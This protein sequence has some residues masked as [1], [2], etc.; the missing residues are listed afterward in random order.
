LRIQE[1]F[2][3][4]IGLL[5]LGLIAAFSGAAAAESS[6]N[7]DEAQRWTYAAGGQDLDALKDFLGRFTEST[8]APEARALLLKR[9]LQPQGK[10]VGGGAK[11]ATILDERARSLLRGYPESP[12]FAAYDFTISPGFLARNSSLE[13]RPHGVS[14]ERVQIEDVIA[15]DVIAQRNGGCSLH[16]RWDIGSG[17]PDDCRCAPLDATYVFE[18]RLARQVLT[19]YS[20]LQGANSVCAANGVDHRE[21]IEAYLDEWIAARTRWLQATRDKQQRKETVFPSEAGEADETEFALPQV[22]EKTLQPEAFDTARRAAAA[23]TLE[24]LGP[25]CREEL[26]ELIENARMRTVLS[27]IPVG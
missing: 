7:G 5:S 6:A 14:S 20:Q 22:R 18:S 16:L 4:R 26:P 15:L 9:R 27:T 2:V 10:L 13:F 3:I 11:C 23:R 17:L 19:G 25:Y 24:R 8:H 1:I 12:R 21:H